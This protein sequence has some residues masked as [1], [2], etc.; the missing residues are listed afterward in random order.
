MSLIEKKFKIS[1]IKLKKNF[2][3]DPLVSLKLEEIPNPE[4][5]PNRPFLLRLWLDTESNCILDKFELNLT[6]IFNIKKKDIFWF[7]LYKKKEDLNIIY[8]PLIKSMNLSDIQKLMQKL[9][10]NKKSK[11]TSSEALSPK[12]RGRYYPIYTEIPLTSEEELKLKDPRKVEFEFKKPSVSGS[13]IMKIFDKVIIEKSKKERILD[14][15]GI[16]NILQGKRV[17]KGGV[18]LVDYGGTGKSEFMKLAEEV[19][20]L[21]GA[22]SKRDSASSIGSY[23]NEAAKKIQEFYFGGETYGFQSNLVE[24]AVKNQIPSLLIVDETEDLIRDTNKTGVNSS[25]KGATASFK[26]ACQALE[27]G[28]AG[29][30]VVTILAA[31]IDPEDIE[32]ALGS[33][34]ERLT[35]VY[36][37]LPKINEWI[38]MI[39]NFIHLTN[40]KLVE[41]SFTNENKKIIAYL[42]Y[43]YNKD[44]EGKN[45]SFT[46]RQFWSFC[47]NYYGEF[48]ESGHEGIIER[49]RDGDYSNIKPWEI[50]FKD[51]FNNLLY[52]IQAKFEQD[53]NPNLL[54][55][56]VNNFLKEIKEKNIDDL[57]KNTNQNIGIETK[58][59]THSLIDIFSNNKEEKIDKTS[60]TKL[61]DFERNFKYLKRNF[62][63]IVDIYKN[64]KKDNLSEKILNEYI[65]KLVAFMYGLDVNLLEKYIKEKKIEDF[66]EDDLKIIIKNIFPIFQNWN[67]NFKNEDFHLS[68]NDFDF[69]QRAIFLLNKLK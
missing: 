26:N 43:M 37:G 15:I 5:D 51:F 44:L 65:I 4:K 18:I 1:E 64:V 63:N 13:E 47:N 8:K 42:L 35:V 62:I 7:K 21:M 39:N 36:L 68:Q 16:Q 12:N 60:E 45:S 2:K 61:E 40:L 53:E 28:G 30:L 9:H 6:N 57:I 69:I 29:G 31:N 23:Q 25:Y 11:I 10:I 14:A 3:I 41:S 34:G 49:I 66:N 46:P 32:S 48:S 58:T 19:W 50:N 27:K 22:E 59:K 20:N 56:K 55:E 38:E 24:S 54:K 17:T 52:L 33:G 67:K